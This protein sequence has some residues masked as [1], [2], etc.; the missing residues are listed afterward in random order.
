MVSN[1]KIALTTIAEALLQHL[2]Q[3]KNGIPDALNF[4][5]MQGVLHGSSNIHFESWP[6][7]LAL[8]YRIDGKLQDVAKIPKK[9][10][11]SLISRIKVLARIVLYHND[12]PRDGRIEAE[13]T[14]SGHALRVSTFPTVS[15]EQAVP[16]LSD[17]PLQQFALDMLGFHGSIA[18]RL[19]EAIFNPPGAMFFTGPSSSGKTT[20][21]YTLL[22]ELLGHSESD[23]THFTPHIVTLEDPIEHKIARISQ[24]EIQPQG[25]FNYRTALRSVLRQNPDVLV[26]GETRDLET[27]QAAIQ[28][29]LTGHLVITTIHSGTATGVFTR[30]LNLGIEPFLIASTITGVLAQ[31]LV[32]R[33]CQQCNSPYEPA[34]MLIKRFDVDTWSPASFQR[35]TGCD[36]YEGLGYHGRTAIGEMLTMNDELADLILSRTSSRKMYDVV[37]RN[38][39]TPIIDHGLKK[40]KGGRTTLEELSRVLPPAATRTTASFAS[41][42]G[43][44]IWGQ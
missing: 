4:A 7:C 32:R 18:Q 25:D 22:G 8:R 30:L 36:T 19:R 1:E 31:R 13:S 17:K 29:G 35:G 3:S 42:W 20:T 34:P 38:E 16:R 14:P 24:A 10:Q 44:V 2:D 28:A 9:F 5:L 39:M 15:G 33:N 11:T 12:M 21:I 26:I 41:E 23:A 40:V 43:Q 6:D 37:I 27:A